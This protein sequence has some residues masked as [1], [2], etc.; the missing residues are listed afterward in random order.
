MRTVTVIFEVDTDNQQVAE[1][2]VHMMLTCDFHDP[3]D[4]I[5]A[6]TVCITKVE[7]E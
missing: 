1:T 7:E 4:R 2:L 3:Y 5:S 6:P